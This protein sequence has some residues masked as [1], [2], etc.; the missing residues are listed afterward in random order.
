M[1]ETSEFAKIFISL[2]GLLILGLLAQWLGQRTAIPRVTILIALGIL[3]GPTGFDV[4]SQ[5]ARDTFPW[6]SQITL[7][8]VGFILG[9]KL[10]FRFLNKHGRDMVSTSLWV[11]L[12]TWVVV[13]ITSGLLSGDWP[14]AFIFGAIATA[15][16]PAA[17]KDVVTESGQ[18]NLFTQLLLGIV[19]LD[20]VWG[21]ILFSLSTILAG[22]FLATEIQHM[23]L[24]VWELCGAVL[25]GIVIGAPIA[26]LSGRSSEGEPLLI[27]ALG[28]VLLCAGIASWLTFP[29]C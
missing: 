13:V 1:Q 24:S 9:G 5:V 21:L 14:L 17:T 22:V 18:N 27:E 19:A 11:T 23:W 8:I 25:L 12:I 4:I 16:D 28:A 7:A 26:W 29:I 20:D 15:T 3:V 10:H 2:G 6:I